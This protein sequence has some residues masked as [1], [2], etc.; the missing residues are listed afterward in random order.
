[1][2]AIFISEAVIVGLLGATFGIG[3]GWLLA[4]VAA[5]IFTGGGFAVSGE[6]GSVGGE[7]AITPVITPTVLLA[8]F[9][10]GIAV[11]VIFAIYPAW[12][13]SRLKPVDALRYE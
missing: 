4:N 3:L 10:F 13:A 7:F 12:R 8:A 2:L 11:S 6:Q 9:G 1:V 5:R